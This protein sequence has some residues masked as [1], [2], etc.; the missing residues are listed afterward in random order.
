MRGLLLGLVSGIVLWTLPAFA[1][2]GAMCGGIAAV[3]CGEKEFC[4]FGDKGTCGAGDQSGVCAAVP[5]A[6]TKEY[7]PVCGCDQKTYPNACEA[8]MAGVSVASAGACGDRSKGMSDETKAAP[9]EGRICPDVISCGI[10]DGEPKEY[11]TPCAA[12][13]DGATDIHSK[14]GDSCKAVQ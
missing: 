3:Q 10:K 4:D 8:H 2:V 9:A 13:D 12:E 11:S 6:C 5:Q 1:E 7:V 14:T